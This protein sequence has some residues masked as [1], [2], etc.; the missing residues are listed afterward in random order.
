MDVYL[1]IHL[2]CYVTPEVE[3]KYDFLAF[4][5]QEFE[6]LYIFFGIIIVD[7]LCE[8]RQIDNHQAKSSALMM[9]IWSVSQES[10]R[11]QNLI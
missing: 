3:D 4:Y 6:R 5:D 10:V 2:T 1:Y 8:L 11:H 9:E 7:G